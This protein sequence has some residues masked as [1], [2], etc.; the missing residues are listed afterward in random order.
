M[1]LNT[2]DQGYNNGKKNGKKGT[3]CGPNSYA[4]Q[5]PSTSLKINF[6]GPCFMCINMQDK[7]MC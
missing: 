5:A 2:V 6:I 7:L 3:L 1:R 4:M